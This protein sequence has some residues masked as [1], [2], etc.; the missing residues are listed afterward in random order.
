VVGPAGGVPEVMGEGIGPG[1]RR[2]S[3]SSS[4][5]RQSARISVSLRVYDRLSTEERVGASMANLLASESG[6]DQSP[7]PA[8]SLPIVSMAR[9]SRERA[10]SVWP[11]YSRPAVAPIS[12]DATFKSVV[13]D[14]AYWR[15]NVH[16][17]EEAMLQASTATWYASLD[18]PLH[19]RRLPVNLLNGV[20]L[21][22]PL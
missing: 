11:E 4:S 2:R 15:C 19:S 13:V 1:V 10:A 14:C 12:G 22:P 3:C 16:G 8:V 21:P 7:A 9:A 20:H 5:E 17:D 6:D 18:A